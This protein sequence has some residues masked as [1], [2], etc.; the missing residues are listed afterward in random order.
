MGKRGKML[1]SILQYFNGL[2]PLLGAQPPLHEV[3]HQIF[4]D[5]AVACMQSADAS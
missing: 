5:P 2:V 4:D 1:T 3:L